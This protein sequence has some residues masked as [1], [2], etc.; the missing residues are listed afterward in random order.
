MGVF[1]CKWV[2]SHQAYFII[3]KIFSNFPIFKCTFFLYNVKKRMF[4]IDPFQ[5]NALVL[6]DQFNEFGVIY[7]GQ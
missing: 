2:V 6:P 3:G 5:E 4:P 7:F 1:L